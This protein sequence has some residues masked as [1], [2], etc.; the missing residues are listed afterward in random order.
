MPSLVYLFV[1]YLLMF[2]AL[3]S[4][5]HNGTGTGS[6]DLGIRALAQYLS[7]IARLG[8]LRGLVLNYCSVLHFV[9]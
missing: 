3:G 4:Y 7:L 1:K 9:M 2:S 8:L 5:F 6:S